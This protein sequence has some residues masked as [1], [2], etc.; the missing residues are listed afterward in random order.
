[1][2][3]DHRIKLLIKSKNISQSELARKLDVTRG[4]VN[5]WLS[6]KQVPGHKPLMK[7]F[8]LFPDVSSDWLLL[9]RGEMSNENKF[10]GSDNS[11]LKK[12]LMDQAEMIGLYK[13]LLSEKDARIKLLESIV[14]STAK[15]P[16]K[17][18][19]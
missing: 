14:N 5:Q 10:S 8:E 19:K 16:A 17:E 7:M 1:M 13:Q 6:G 11:F 18:K 4:S 3:L 2:S 15:S 9:G 12:Q